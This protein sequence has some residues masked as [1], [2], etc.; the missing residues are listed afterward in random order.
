MSDDSKVPARHSSTLPSVVRDMTTGDHLPSGREFWFGTQ[1]GVLERRKRVVDNSTA[2]MLSQQQQANAYTG[3][4]DARM[5]TARKFGELADLPNLLA[6]DQREREHAR[7]LSEHRRVL[8]NV[9]AVHALHVAIAQHDVEI[10]RI[11]EQGVRADRNLEAARRVKDAEIDAWYQQAAARRNESEATRQDTDADLHRTQSTANPDAVKA[12]MEEQLAQALA[13]VE[14]Q[15]E[16]ERERGNLA[17]V[18]ALSNVR[19][20]LRAA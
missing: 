20:R 19:A 13:A 11:R 4:I 6:D 9:N 15:I 17:G 8:E 16:L 2:L 10:A 3:L 7:A 12:A 1:A 18:M 14:H 5:R